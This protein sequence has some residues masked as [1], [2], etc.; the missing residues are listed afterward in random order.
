MQNE[1]LT[2]TL[3]GVLLEEARVAAVAEGLT[4]EE[5]IVAKLARASNAI[6]KRAPRHNEQ[7]LR[8]RAP[9]PSFGRE[10]AG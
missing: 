10:R 8:T 3:D 9:S 2:I 4:T 5:W 7:T 1:P 6:T